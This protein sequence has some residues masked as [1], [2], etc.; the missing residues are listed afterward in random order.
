MNV[1]QALADVRALR[2]TLARSRDFPLLSPNYVLFTGLAG[3]AAAIYQF[4]LGTADP[5]IDRDFVRYWS[6][7]GAVLAGICLISVAGRYLREPSEWSWGILRDTC[8]LFVPPLLVG[9]LLTW[10]VMLRAPAAMAILP[11][12]WALLFGCAVWSAAAKFPPGMGGVAIYYFLAGIGLIFTPDAYLSA[13]MGVAF[14]GGQ[15]IMGGFLS[16]VRQTS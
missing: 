1:H 4:A 12:S 8:L 9:G 2:A 7:Q 6:I 3:G 16:Y 10:L 15:L 13:G 5:P 14:G 11:A